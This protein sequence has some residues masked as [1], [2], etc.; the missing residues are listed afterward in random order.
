M[1]KIV[2]GFLCSLMILNITGCK[3]VPKLKTGEDA[4]VSF[5]NE[6]LDISVDELYNSLKERYGVDFLVELIDEKILDQIY[7]RDEIAE[8]YLDNQVETYESYYGDEEGLLRALQNAGYQ[9]IDQFKDT[10]VLDYKRERALKD[11]VRKN[12]TEKEINEYF[13]KE[14]FGD[15]TAS[16]I[17]IS[18]DDESAMTSDE[19]RT[20]E[21]IALDTIDEILKKLEEGGDFHELA[22]EY[23]KDEANA[24]NGGRLEAFNKG[25]MEEEFEKAAMELEVGKYT[26]KAVKTQYGYHLIYKESQK[27]KPKLEEVKETILDNL[28]DEKIEEDDKL[29]Y[30]AL[31]E[32][33]KEYGI[34][35]NDEE[36]NMYYDNAVN[37]WLYSKED[38]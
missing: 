36:L 13:E 29:Q 17:L 11:Y 10:L 20:E 30:K 12:I 16:H 7:E 19:K 3:D 26:T 24:S 1:K 22:K 27:E 32:L 4:V 38:E 31:I 35:I 9:T 37:N 28:V 14:I 23:S 2:Y 15:I 34:V 6:K 5:D 21:E 8:K 18:L 33:R 25:E